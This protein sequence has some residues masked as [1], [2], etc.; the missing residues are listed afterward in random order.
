MRARA[1]Y[2]AVLFAFSAPLL[3]AQGNRNAAN[4]EVQVL[5]V[6]GNVYM[7]VGAGGNI[8]VQAGD[9]GVLIV[10]A[11]TAAMSDEVLAAIHSISSGTLIYVVNTDENEEH[12]GG[13]AK[14]ALTGAPVGFHNLTGPGR[15]GAQ[16]AFII[17]YQTIFDRMSAPTGSKAPASEDAWP[18]DTYSIP[19]KNLYFNGEPIQIMHQPGNT[20]GNSIV[21]FR[22]SDVIS[23]GDIL[24]LSEYPIIDVNAGGSIQAIKQGLDRLIELAVVKS[25]S[26]GGTMII[27]GHGRLCDQADVVVYD[28]MVTVVSDR[29]RDMIS[30]GMT[31]QQVKDAKPTADWA[32]LYGKTSGPWTTDM[33]VEAA[34]KS[35]SAKGKEA[36]KK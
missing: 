8:T 25:H 6:Q 24:D 18:N 14:I 2:L 3:N 17:A 35:L 13:N 31:L 19:T 4:N 10:D 29:I 23:A 21:L 11:G 32:P 22:K 34:Y 9:D 26:E 7:L 16:G 36:P 12:T 27:P 33:F 1:I 5:P 20:D 15:A 28:Q 30:H